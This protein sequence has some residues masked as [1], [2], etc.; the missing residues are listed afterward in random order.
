MK[1]QAYFDCWPCFKAPETCWRQSDRIPAK[2]S[3]WKWMK[4]ADSNDFRVNLNRLWWGRSILNYFGSFWV[5]FDLLAQF[6][7]IFWLPGLFVRDLS[8]QAGV[9]SIRTVALKKINERLVQRKPHGLHDV[10][11]A[12]D[13][14][15]AH[16]GSN[17]GL[18]QRLGLGQ[19]GRMLSNASNT[20]YLHL[21]K[22]AQTDS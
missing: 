8:A 2:G 14:P 1:A 15:H 4:M 10:A 9:A 3:G 12:N 18:W 11:H 20:I 7:V 5:C 16:D 21:Q 17:D 22:D 13:G 6:S 19:L